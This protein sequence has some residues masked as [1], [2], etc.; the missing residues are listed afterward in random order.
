MPPSVALW[1]YPLTTFTIPKCYIGWR[2]LAFGGILSP[3]YQND[4]T[5]WSC[6][7][8]VKAN[9]LL[10]NKQIGVRPAKPSTSIRFLA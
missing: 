3:D 4:V 1:S 9:N 7:V 6:I 5:M 10:N 2:L 8:G